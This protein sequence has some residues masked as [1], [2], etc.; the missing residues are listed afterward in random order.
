[1]MGKAIGRKKVKS[2][3]EWSWKIG[4]QG[5]W[6]WVEESSISK[7]GIKK[8]FSGIFSSR[9]SE[10]EKEKKNRGWETQSLNKLG[11]S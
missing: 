8:A 3:R 2:V 10:K 5:V 4:E 6:D 7:G 1:M 11:Y 9:G